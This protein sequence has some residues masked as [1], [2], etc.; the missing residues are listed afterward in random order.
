LDDESRIPRLND[1]GGTIAVTL[2]GEFNVNGD[3]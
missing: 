3:S 2:P 1:E